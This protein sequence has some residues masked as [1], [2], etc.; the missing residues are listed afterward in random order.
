MAKNIYCFD[1]DGTVTAE[2]ILP[3]I[4]KELDL[5]DEISALTQATINGLIPFERSFKLRCKI[6]SD[7]PVKK[8]QEIAQKVKLNQS[9]VNFLNENK[10]NSYIVTGNIYEW[11]EPII[12]KLGCKIICSQGKF[13]D[14]KLISLEKIINK[15]DVIKGLKKKNNSIISIGDGMGDVLMF[16]ESDVSV[17]FGGVHEP[18][19][20]LMKVSDF[21]VYEE[22][23]LCRLLN[24]L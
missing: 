8:V 3:L 24:T 2:E 13:I 22:D 12:N 17:A 11:I 18:I 20:T 4:A 15:G 16:E 14:G 7:V 21:L 19:E 1:L 10:D 5:Y 6:L 23:S 9:I